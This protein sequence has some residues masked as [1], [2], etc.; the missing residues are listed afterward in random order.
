[1]T[2]TEAQE[3]FMVALL[4]ATR[5]KTITW[6]RIYLDDEPDR[7]IYRTVV[8][9]EVLEIEFEAI[10]LV[11]QIPPKGVKNITEYALVRISGMKL[12]ITAAVGTKI[13]SI[14]KEIVDSETENAIKEKRIRS[15]KKAVEKLKNAGKV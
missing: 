13:F 12:W 4:T 7:D 14:S 9:G 5:D 8:N 2:D 11:S 1:M 3:E 10:P 15:Y 6:E